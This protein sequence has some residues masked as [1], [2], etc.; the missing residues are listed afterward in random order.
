MFIVGG[1]P[2]NIDEQVVNGSDLNQKTPPPFAE[3]IEV[4]NS[5]KNENLS[6]GMYKSR[7]Q[8]NE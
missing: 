5:K 6:T 3:G 1:P 8:G 4:T 2:S 7:R